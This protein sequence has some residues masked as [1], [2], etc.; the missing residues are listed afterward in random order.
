MPVE[1]YKGDKI[2]SGC[3]NLSGVLEARVTKFTRIPSSQELWKLWRRR[4]TVNPK[5]SIC[6][7]IFQS[8]CTDHG[9]A[10]CVDHGCSA[11]YIFL[12]KLGD[13]DL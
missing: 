6:D 11:V 13:M 9:I 7:E 1:V 8:I 3:I 10:V 4:R 5:R 12:R 2:Y